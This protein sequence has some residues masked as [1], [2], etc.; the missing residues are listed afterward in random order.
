MKS[1]QNL[2]KIFPVP[3][4][5]ANYFELLC[6]LPGT[7]YDDSED[8]PLFV[9]VVEKLVRIVEKA[10]FS[11]LNVP[12]I[13][14]NTNTVELWSSKMIYI[15]PARLAELQSLKTTE[16]DLTKLVRLCEEINICF[17]NKCYLAT[18]MLTRAVLD[19]VSPIFGYEN[20]I[21][22][23]NN[24]SGAGRSFKDAMLHLANSSKKIADSYL[25]LQVRQKESLPNKTQ[26]DFRSDLDVF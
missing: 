21:E 25:H 24:Y 16:F 18:A 1:S 5:A 26:V 6:F 14:P 2:I 23:A 8:Y 17:S 12:T 7:E 9:E 19:H 15:D 22:V 4:C 20:F 3:G 13:V 11:E 10:D